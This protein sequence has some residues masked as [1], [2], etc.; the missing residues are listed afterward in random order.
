MATIP[1]FGMNGVLSTN[2]SVLQ[3]LN[4]L[5]TSCGSWMTYDSNSGLWSV[6]INKPGDSVKSFNDSN[7][8]G[9]ISISG[10]GI[11]EFYN[12]VS[13]E[14]PHKDLRDVT[15]YVDFEITPN[16]RFTNEQDNK[17]NTSLK[18][19]NDPVQAAFIGQVELKQSRVDKVIEFGTDYSALGLRAGEI[20]DITS[21]IYGYTNKKFRITKLQEAD[22]DNGSI[23]VKIV[24]LEYDED[25]YSETGLVRTERT[26]KT[27]IMPK[28]LNQ[29]LS[30]EDANALASGMSIADKEFLNQLAV[31]LSTPLAQMGGLTKQIYTQEFPGFYLQTNDEGADTLVP[32]GNSLT[33]PTTGKYKCIYNLNWGSDINAYGMDSPPLGVF[34]RSLMLLAI[35]GVHIPGTGDD[36]ALG[37]TGDGFSPLFEDHYLETFFYANEGDQLSMALKYTTN[38]SAQHYNAYPSK[39][40]M[41]SFNWPAG[42]LASIVM[43]VTVQLVGA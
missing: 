27:G 8:I 7:I 17:L 42:A 31:Q 2:N 37:S 1:R 26:K 32:I 41:P 29:A 21:E 16:Q 28:S 3:N 43:A 36:A 5:C 38:A 13:V 35:N 14:F 22:D 12:S 34:K 15:D 39:P 9:S 20:I 24:A 23:V 18:Y 4:D 25:V 11:D 10:T 40:G 6:V 33:L 19:I 30:K